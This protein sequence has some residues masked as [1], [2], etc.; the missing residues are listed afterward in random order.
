LEYQ[1]LNPTTQVALFSVCVD[2]CTLISNITW[3]VY[4][5]VMNSSSDI[6]QWT[7]F[8][9]MNQYENIWFFGKSFLF[10][11]I[12]SFALFL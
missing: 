2:N 1:F 9:Q 5:G 10:P 12:L 3:N 11:F 7:L 8:N 6:V 4:Q